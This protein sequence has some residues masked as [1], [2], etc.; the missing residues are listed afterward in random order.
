[1]KRT[2]LMCLA[3][4]LTFSAILGCAAIGKDLAHNPPPPGM[5]QWENQGPTGEEGIPG[6]GELGYPR[7]PDI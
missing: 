3:I 5:W 6:E 7:V 2:I 1:M 4:A